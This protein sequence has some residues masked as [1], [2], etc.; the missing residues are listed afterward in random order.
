[1]NHANKDMTRLNSLIS[2]N[3]DLAAALE[4]K[5]FQLEY[6]VMAELKDQ[7]A[8]AKQVESS[9]EECTTNKNEL[10]SE[11]LETERQIMLWERKLQLDREMQQLLDP[12]VGQVGCPLHDVQ[13]VLCVPVETDLVLQDVLGAMKKEIHR[14]ELRK[15]DLERV[16]E[17]LMKELEKS[18]DKRDT[19]S[20]KGRANAG[21]SKK[22]GGKLIEKQLAKKS[23]E[24]RQSIA[25]TDAECIA[26]DT[27]TELLSQKR[28]QLAEKMQ[29]ISSSCID[30]R[31]RDQQV[32]NTVKELLH[33]K[34]GKSLQTQVIS[35]ASSMMEQ[36]TLN[37][38]VGPP[39]QP[40]D[41]QHQHNTITNLVNSLKES[42]PDLE[43]DAQ[44][45]MLHAEA[46][47]VL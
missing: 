47:R 25:D 23:K 32:R 43:L 8:I 15:A 36:H 4:D 18:V 28:A 24:L 35:T 42:H 21:N 20:L 38:D 9:I 13:N 30:L 34:L 37:Q 11:V 46:I 14:M 29:V 5:H 26:V 22:A 17:Q 1:M 19:I 16:K 45:I 10:L 27:R 31:Q 2:S 6:A 40:N 39:I 33:D 44:R 7:E 12:T 3:T 41:V